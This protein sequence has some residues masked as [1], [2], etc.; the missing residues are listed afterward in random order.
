MRN[1]SPELQ[2]DWTQKEGS[3]SITRWGNTDWE[4]LGGKT[5]V[6]DQDKMMSHLDVTI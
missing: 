1:I 4:G 2:E 3:L 6:N 5:T